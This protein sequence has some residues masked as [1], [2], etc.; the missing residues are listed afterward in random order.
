MMIIQPE[1]SLLSKF[2][3]FFFLWWVLWFW[4][5]AFLL[6]LI[7]NISNWRTKQFYFLKTYFGFVLLNCFEVVFVFL[8]RI[9]NL[10]QGRSIWHLVAIFPHPF[11]LPCLKKN[12]HT[13][14]RNL[15]GKQQ[16]DI[17]NPFSIHV[18]MEENG[19][20]NENGMVSSF[21]Q[22]SLEDESPGSQAVSF[23]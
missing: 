18:A 6:F 20:I 12:I 17:N 14:S 22:N 7:E 3:Q 11:H 19:L 23:C 13:G 4:F 1:P 16:A 10:Y 5:F 2:D 9:I 21:F 15:G 8:D